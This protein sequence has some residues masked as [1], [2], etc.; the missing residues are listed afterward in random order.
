MA[1]RAELVG[2][3]AAPRL[4]GA[5]RA[6][7]SDFFFNSSRL[8]PVNVLW[9]IAVV[10]VVLVG[11]AWPLGA[12]LLA[13]F[14]AFPTAVI[15]RVAARIV[16]LDGDVSIRDAITAGRADAGP[17]LALGVVYVFGT[18]ILGSNLVVGLTQA[19]PAGLVLGT[20]AAWGLCVLWSGAGVAWP[21]LV[22][23]RMAERPARERLRI[24]GLLFLAHPARIALLGA[25]IAAITVVSTVLTAAILTISVAFVAL[26]SC[27]YVYPAAERLE[28]QL[29]DR[30]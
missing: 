30:R 11:M 24:A 1:S 25:A 14:L 15:F 18:L 4:T 2:V 16:R 28:R 12:L 10:F 20:F 21:M 19:E 5:L 23:P 26:V 13:P 6:A 7:M 17:T 22:D 9:G 29:G 27:R 3:P 8:V